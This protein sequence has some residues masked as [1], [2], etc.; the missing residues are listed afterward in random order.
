[1]RSKAAGGMPTLYGQFASFQEWAEIDSVAEGHY[2]ERMAPSVF[3]NSIAEDRD[4]IRCLYHHGL[5]PFF[6][7]R[8]S[9]RS[10]PWSRTRPTRS[11]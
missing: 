4:R 2:L 10:A 11:T 1:M 9:A 6:A 3:E 8:L 7:L 5:G